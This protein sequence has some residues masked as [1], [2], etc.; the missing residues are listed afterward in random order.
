MSLSTRVL[1][2]LVAGVATG[3]FLGEVAAP[4]S[5]VG[6]AFILSLQVT[7]LPFMM[8]ALISALGRL[9]GNT[10]L[11]IARSGGLVLVALWAIIMAVVL[12]LPGAFPDWESASFFSR[13]LVETPPPVDF[14]DLYIPSNPFS[15]MARSIVPAIVVFSIAVGVA[16]IGIERKG[17]LL[18]VLEVLRTALDRITGFVVRLAPY[19]VF[20]L[21]ASAAGT[22]DLADL[23]RIQVYVVVYTGVALV[24]VFWV[25]P[26]LVATLTPLRYSQVLGPVR[27]ALVTAFATGN[28]LI[29]LPILADRGKQVLADAGVEA[30]VSESVVD[31][32]VPASFTIP[33]MGKLLSLAFVPFAGWFTGFELAPS[34]YPLFA[35]VGFVSFFGE[36][37]VSLPFLLNLLRIPADTFDLFITID[38][39]TSRLGTLLAAAHTV[40]LALLAAFVMSGRLKVRW[41]RL[42]MFVVGSTILLTVTIVGTRA[43]FTH[44]V[45]PQYTGYREFIEMEPVIEPVEARELDAEP[46]L[47]PAERAS[48]SRLEL[49]RERGSLRVGYFANALPWAF[50]N[51]RGELVGFDVEM[52]HLLARDLDVELELVQIARPDVASYLDDGRCDLVV[53]GTVITPQGAEA[54]H[55]SRSLGDLT[56]AF[57]VPQEERQAFTEW[58]DL[59]RREGLTLGLGPN[60]YYRRRLETLLPK[61]RIVSLS[62]PREFFTAEPGTIDALVLSAEVG[63]AWTLVYPRYA[64]AV[65]GPRSIVVPVAY[66]MP[67]GATRLHDVVDAFVLLKSSDG[68]RK[69]LFDHWFEGLSPTQERPRW[70][71]AHDV[72]GWL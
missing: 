13:S 10:A 63:S 11:R 38:V 20:A 23:G 66:A 45:E 59:Q 7:V 67:Q 48:A 65:P 5:V 71:V 17:P 33:N 16:L 60:P 1:I 55:Y 72:L 36:P 27:D 22:L 12:S 43:L 3:L 46:P 4:L 25:L 47:S 37:V 50:H 52:T 28:L 53:S 44:G 39:I 18:E 30:E 31:V 70:S 14:L 57:V 8:V 29:V 49:I 42:A 62:S 6:N 40:V 15:S 21:M 68:T 54:V 69:R 58:D 9:D 24:L 41:P 26:G 64:V 35:S 32:L 2:G 51:A 19:G 56:A 34:Q 61:A